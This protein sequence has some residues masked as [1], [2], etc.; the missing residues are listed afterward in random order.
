M[1]NDFITIASAQLQKLPKS[2]QEIAVSEEV[3]NK[4]AEISREQNLSQN[5]STKL[6]TEVFLLLLLF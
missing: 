3:E 2:I 4:L 5:Q 6:N 1:E